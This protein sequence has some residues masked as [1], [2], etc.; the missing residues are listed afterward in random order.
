MSKVQR[1]RGRRAFDAF[2]QP[3]RRAAAGVVQVRWAPGGLA[4]AVAY[5]ISRRIGG[6]VTRNRVRR[7]LR[8]AFD[9]IA[10][11]SPQLLPAGRYLVTVSPAAALAPYTTI[12]GDLDGAL[13]SLAVARPRGAK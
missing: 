9:E 2:H 10:D 8:A 13:R 7:R 6:A 3:Q 4:P 5:A 1:V 12:V 11:R